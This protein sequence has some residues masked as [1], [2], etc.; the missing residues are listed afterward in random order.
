MFWPAVSGLKSGKSE[1]WA[2]KR[3][4]SSLNSTQF[5]FIGQLLTI[6]VFDHDD[7]GDDEFLG[8]ATVSTSVVEERGHIEKMWAELEDV[9]SGKVQLSLSWLEATTDK[10]VL[11]GWY[12]YI[13]QLFSS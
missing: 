12:T 9:K 8:R 4:P 2:P 3:S 11:Q 1:I 6:E 5:L 7:P 13:S 10:S